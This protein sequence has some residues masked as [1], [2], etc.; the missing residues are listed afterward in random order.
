MVAVDVPHGVVWQ[1]GIIRVLTVEPVG[2]LSRTNET[3]KKVCPHLV[4]QPPV[5]RDSCAKREGVCGGLT[6]SV[7][8]LT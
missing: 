2:L 8:L 1:E 4:L 7:W 5:L 3:I 6:L